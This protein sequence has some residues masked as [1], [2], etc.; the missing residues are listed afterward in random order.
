MAQSDQTVQN[1]TFPTVRADINNNLAALFSNSSGSSAPTVTVAYMD[2]VDT[3]GAN[4]VWKKR[5]A[6]NN[7]WIT[8]ATI[9]GNSI[10]FSQADVL[11]DQTGNSG[12]FLTTN[13]TV[14][15]WAPVPGGTDAQVFTASGT[16]TKPSGVS[17]VYVE[18]WGAGGGGGKGDGAGG[19]GG[20]AFR[21]GFIKA[22][23]LAASVSVTVG[24][25]GAGRTG[26]N[27]AGGN[28]GSSSFAGLIAG[29]GGGGDAFYG[30]GGGGWLTSGS[31]GVVGTGYLEFGA[32]SGD[33]AENALWVGVSGGDQA[34]NGGGNV[35]GGGGGGGRN[36]ATVRSG[37]TSIFGG[38]GGDGGGA[39]G[40]PGGDGVA[41]SGGGG[42]AAGADAG[43]GAR[44]EVRIY[45][46]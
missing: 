31:L 30:G 15:S 29:G 1:D 24:T 3:S 20:G 44:G 10:E 39:N 17:I 25:G 23:D 11:P 12:E 16:W 14:A 21:W 18:L 19:G 28:G 45:A 43:D 33:R 4:P 5:N 8:I 27:G 46:W 6:A 22:S 36:N 26:T 13:G 32:G 34:Q 41:P 42:A 38:D 40:N 35:Y 9:V 7:A 2:W 37:G